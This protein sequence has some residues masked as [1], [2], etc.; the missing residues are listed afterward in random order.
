[1]HH[2]V[3]CYQTVELV[4]FLVTVTHKS[5]QDFSSWLTLC[6]TTLV[7]IIFHGD[8]MHVDGLSKALIFT[9][10]PC[11]DLILPSYLN[12]IFSHLYPNLNCANKWTPSKISDIP[13]SGYQLLPFLLN[14]TR[15]TE[16]IFFYPCLYFSLP[17]LSVLIFHL[18]ECNFHEQSF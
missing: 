14:F 7:K 4:P 3:L 8:F 11:K 15:R 16:M 17:L 18:A 1:M 2:N 6:K 13:L 5:L 12:R 9:P 10:L